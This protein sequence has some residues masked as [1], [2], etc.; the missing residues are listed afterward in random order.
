MQ[1]LVAYIEGHV[2]ELVD[3]LISSLREAEPLFREA[4]PARLQEGLRDAFWH[5]A[6]FAESRS[7]RHLDVAFQ[8]FVSPWPG[9][10]PPPSLVI[11]TFFQFEDL[12][13]I[14]AQSL[15]L[16][17][18]DF[19]DAMRA[20]RAVTRE[21]IAGICD[22]LVDPR[23]G[24]GTQ[25]YGTLH[26]SGPSSSVSLH[27]LVQS[28]PAVVRAL[29]ERLARVRPVGR[30]DELRQVWARLRVVTSH[31]GGH[32][33][34][35]IK[36]P[37]GYGKT[38]LVNTFLERVE[39]QIDG[40]PMVLRTRVPRLFN[41]PGWPIAALVREA[42]H[43]SLGGDDPT[44]RLHAGLTSLTA[45]APRLPVDRE[46][47]VNGAAHLARM[48]G[49]DGTDWGRPP[50]GRAGR[51]G[52]LRVLVAL[53]EALSLRARQTTRGPLFVVIEDAGEMDLPSWDVLRHL[54][55]RV[56]PVAP[57]MVL[58]TYDARFN[59][60][61]SMQR[62]PNFNE[63]VLQP[64]DMNEGEQLIDGLLSPNQ[65]D[66]QTRL[67]LHAGTQSSPLLL[68]EALRQLVDD[69]II[70]LD[71]DRWVEIA[72]LPEGEIGEL[73]MIVARRRA[74]LD[75]VAIEVLEAITVIEDT[76]DHQLLSALLTRRGIGPEAQAAAL[77]TLRLHGLIEPTV[78]SD[79]PSVQARHPLVR[80]EIY[81]QMS[82][83]RRRA[84]HHDAGELLFTLPAVSAFPSLAA[85]HLALAR[86]PER[87][88]AGLLNAID[89]CLEVHE[90]G[91]ALELCNQ[92]LAL[93][94]GLPRPAHDRL[95]VEV[96]RR[97]ERLFAY[98]GQH[99]LRAQDFQQI[100]AL[101]DDTAEL[102]Q[103]RQDALR[104]A[105][106][107][108]QLGDHESAEEQLVDL[109]STSDVVE[110]ARVR[111]AL[112]VNCWQQGQREEATI[113][114]DEVLR[115]PLDGL[116][117][118]L[119]ARLLHLRGLS[120]AAEGAFREAHHRLFEGWRN[121][122]RAGDS[123][124]EAL[125][126]EPLADLFWTSGRLL[127]AQALL[128]RAEALLAEMD[129]QRMRARILLKLAHLHSLFGDHDR[130][131]DLYYEVLQV[132]D[133]QR[134][135]LLQ[136]EASISKGSIL[137]QQGRLEEATKLLGMCLKDLGGRKAVREPL[138]V[139]ALLAL[140]S[141]LAFF[142]RGEKLVQGGMRYAGEAADRAIEIG[143]HDGLV[144]A[145]M[146][147]LRGLVMLD[148]AEEARDRLPEL[149]E[150]LRA[151][152]AVQPRLARLQSEVELCRYRIHKALGDEARAAVAIERAW[153][154]LSRQ[155]GL[156]RGSGYERDFLTNILPHREIVGVIGDRPEL[157]GLGLAV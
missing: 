68:H 25:A 38:T 44:E 87:A 71:G 106:L 114:L 21:V 101:A 112:A 32:Q 124:G 75:A 95:F 16:D 127:D 62:N 41:L 61:A 91:G 11:R 27:D 48:L 131:G 108:V 20:I 83:E 110:G 8:T 34:V 136:A 133:K 97:R 119:R 154:E 132:T 152:L 6:L 50:S 153:T 100:A 79:T 155:L 107:A 104:R 88:V 98:I 128:Q 103:L 15:Y 137:A 80:D 63:V 85:G 141:N 52:R 139:E 81:R 58:L 5:Y 19:I 113:F 57:L 17:P 92:A 138:Y 3:D 13:I 157:A 1:N 2:Y 59:A 120:H 89:R 116:P 102:D 74:R 156:L 53:F 130:A 33:V 117:D 121:Y 31:E 111:L 147:Q 151:A 86:Q 72:R 22:R 45:L 12:V 60:P 49:I 40:R 47:L 150:A 125:A 126:I 66:E 109:M 90:V 77:D 42:F 115:G 123:C 140:A 28:D 46:T 78:S 73:A 94:K 148:R 54:L 36:A 4:A 134:D 69:G 96:L 76:I 7:P 145:L 35:G 135:R 84:L 143:H 26:D 37:D 51:I 146:I 9:G 70:G 43:I 29:M 93:L 144:R 142:A 105:T 82:V 64:F 118:L 10:H 30:S 99:E 39:R 122:R 18:D 149:D 24:V 65:L 129:E 14:R 23:S 55:E 67:R 56:R